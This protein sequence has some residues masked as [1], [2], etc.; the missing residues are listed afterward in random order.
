MGD[1]GFAPQ[2]MIEILIKE[3]N[4]GEFIP[5][6]AE[7]YQLADDRTAMTFKWRKGVKF[8]DGSDFNATVVKWNLENV[9]AAKQAP[10]WS[11]VDIVD[12]YTVRIN[13]SKWQNTMWSGF[14][15][16]MISKAAF[17]EHGIDWVRQNPVGTGPYKFVSYEKDAS[18][19]GIKNPD[20]CQS[21]KWD[22][23]QTEHFG[24]NQETL[25]SSLRSRLYS[26]RRLIVCI[27]TSFLRCRISSRLPYKTSAGVTLLKAL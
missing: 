13:L 25:T 1:G 14:S 16:S 9:M 5:W 2:L 12:D 22:T 19:T 18:F 11:S 7:S 24:I 3:N 4:K 10:N 15:S 27:C 26:L 8:H 17:D 23:F 20:C 21:A 6:L